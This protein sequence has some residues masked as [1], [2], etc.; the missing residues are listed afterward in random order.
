MTRVDR[1]R[2][3]LEKHKQMED[4][5]TEE[6]FYAELWRRDRNNKE[7][8]ESQI[9][10]AIKDRNDARNK[11]LSDQFNE[12]QDNKEK[13]KVMSQNEKDMLKDQWDYELDK[14]KNQ[15]V[16]IAALNKKMNQEIRDQNMYYKHQKEVEAEKIK[17]WDKNRVREV[18]EREKILDQ[19][20]LEKRYLDF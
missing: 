9:Q 15:D 4:E 7:K 13:S 12:M 17:D 10:A 18:I 20:D 8:A 5:F 11:I 14:Q 19:L 2:Q 3:V 6:M 1:E 16:E